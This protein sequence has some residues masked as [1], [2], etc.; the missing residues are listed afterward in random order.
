MKIFGKQFNF[1]DPLQVDIL[2]F[3]ETNNQILRKAINKN[4]SVG[5]FYQQ[6]PSS[7][8]IGIKV[9][10][11]FILNLGYLQIKWIRNQSFQCREKI[12]VSI[13]KNFRLI[14]YKSCIDVIKPKAVVTFI[15]NSPY[16]GWLS[17]NCKDC[18]FIGI[19]N[20]RRLSYIR[21]KDYNVQHLFSYGEQE[22]NYFS[23]IGYHVDN[24]YPAGSLVASLHFDPKLQL[25]KEIYDLL[26]VSC[27]RGNI[28]FNQDVK[29]S[30]KSMRIMDHL[31]A[32]Y[33]KSRNIKAAVILRCERDSR[34]WIMPDIKEKFEIDYFKNIYGDSLDIIET[35]FSNVAHKDYRN[36]FPLMQ[37]SKVITSWLSSA[38]LE[39][40]GIGKK[41]LYCNFSGTNL[42][43]SE[44]DKD[45]V[46]EK[47]NF[48][49]FSKLMDSLIAHD[50]E[51][52][53]KINKEK[54][55]YYMSFPSDLSTYNF[56]SN[57]IDEIIERSETLN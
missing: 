28:G 6:K 14:Y 37:K 31:L 24:F 19:Q 5:I 43:H 29:D 57:K 32:Q 33:V 22:K 11:N 9:F 56:I 40:F 38:L 2:I 50:P 48:P 53:K 35:N 36:I 18:P 8:F 44:V 55:N 27:W 49:E 17:R 39:A 26:I 52:Y 7:I 10:I 21:N 51:D 25:Q 46:T 41:V 13:W 54:M 34:D 30:M 42:Y 12:M 23:K 1:R 45:L 16:F 15:D 20:G 4:Y 47:S 3:D